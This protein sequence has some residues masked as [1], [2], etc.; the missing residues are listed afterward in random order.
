[1]KDR[2]QNIIDSPDAFGM[3][4]KSRRRH[5]GM[6]QEMLASVCGI[7]QPN[8]SRIENGRSVATLGTCLRLCAQLGVDLVGVVRQ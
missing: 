4:V 1:M 8:L 2:H 7:P 3:L 6:S 5:L